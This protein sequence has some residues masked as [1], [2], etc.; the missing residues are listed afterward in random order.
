MISSE[1]LTERYTPHQPA[2]T[3]PAQHILMQRGTFRPS[4]V[5]RTASASVPEPAQSPPAAKPAPHIIRRI[6][7][8]KLPPPPHYKP[9]APVATTTQPI[10]PATWPTEPVQAVKPL[11]AQTME[12]MEQDAIPRSLVLKFMR[13][14]RIGQ[15]V[16]HIEEDEDKLH[17]AMVPQAISQPAPIQAFVQNRVPSEYVN[18]STV[19][20]DGEIEHAAV[21]EAASSDRDLPLE[22][23]VTETKNRWRNFG[24]RAVSKTVL[25]LIEYSGIGTL[26][27]IK[28]RP[29]TDPLPESMEA[30]LLNLEYDPEQIELS[31]DSLLEDDKKSRRISKKSLL[32]AS[33]AKKNVAK[34]S[35]IDDDQEYVDN[36]QKLYSVDHNRAVEMVHAAVAAAK[37]DPKGPKIVEMHKNDESDEIFGVK[38]QVEGGP[39]I[40]FAPSD[41]HT[42]LKP[43]FTM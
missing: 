9:K 11:P 23:V 36:I 12:P 15:D 17:A 1:E 25:P 19:Q 31:V 2:P 18:T 24:R 43:Y 13:W 30:D 3:K 27:S 32:R 41:I 34:E 22:E 21:Q 37:S 29:N 40:S 7:A 42:R 6:I 20:T 4:A 16:I 28:L 38:I 26:K 35:G 14:M 39:A 5:S 33:R 10:N 8:K